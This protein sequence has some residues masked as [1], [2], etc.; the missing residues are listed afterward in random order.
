MPCSYLEDLSKILHA[1]E[2]PHETIVG[3]LD[4]VTGILRSAQKL[5]IQVAGM[6]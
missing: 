5:G 1:K 2:I 4:D 6:M 3:T